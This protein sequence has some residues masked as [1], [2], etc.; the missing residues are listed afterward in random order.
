MVDGSIC[1]EPFDPDSA[2]DVRFLIGRDISQSVLEDPEIRNGLARKE[3]CSVEVRVS[4][5]LLAIE[6]AASF[7]RPTNPSIP[8]NRLWDFSNRNASMLVA[9]LAHTRSGHWFL[10]ST[11][12]TSASPSKQYC[13]K[14]SI[15]N[16]L[17]AQAPKLGSS[18]VPTDDRGEHLETIEPR[19]QYGR[20][21]YQWI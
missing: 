14:S 16:S 7:D 17:L 3:I 11:E 12:H 10:C 5:V 1:R 21:A 4:F 9:A 6:D 19:S 18:G 2:V 15:K 13:C 20:R 8:R